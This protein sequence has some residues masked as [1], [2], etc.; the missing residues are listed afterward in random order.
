MN[1]KEAHMFSILLNSESAG[2][3]LFLCES[4]VVMG[5]VLSSAGFEAADSALFYLSLELSYT[6]IDDRVHEKRLI[7]LRPGI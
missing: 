4:Y 1:H 6:V 3:T 2:D 5:N 7:S